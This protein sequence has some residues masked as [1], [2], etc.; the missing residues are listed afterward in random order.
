MFNTYFYQ[1][2]NNQGFSKK[3]ILLI[4]KIFSIIKYLLTITVNFLFQILI[5]NLFKLKRINYGINNLLNNH[6]QLQYSVLNA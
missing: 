4:L 2:S 3:N 5:D 6:Q 1:P